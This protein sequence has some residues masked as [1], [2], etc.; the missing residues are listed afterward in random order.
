MN[1]EKIRKEQTIDFLRAVN[2]KG[3]EDLLKYIARELPAHVRSTIKYDRTYLHDVGNGSINEIKG[4]L[5]V[6]VKI[7]DFRA[8]GGSDIF[9]SQPWLTNPEYI[10]SIA[11]PIV[12][13]K[14]LSEYSPEQRKL[15]KDVKEVAD[16][17]FR[18]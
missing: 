15:W 14:E 8:G 17:Y 9:K 5:E 4:S 1:I 18:E 2:R 10:I 6:T 7:E 13:D 12:F 3:A 11:A 16:R